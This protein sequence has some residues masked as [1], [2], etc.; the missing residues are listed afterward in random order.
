MEII[1]LALVSKKVDFSWIFLQ[2]ST[3]IP[4]S[5]TNK[6][7]FARPLIV[8]FLVFVFVFGG[9]NLGIRPH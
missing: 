9:T 8:Y 2:N 6:S 1:E 5:E 7:K 4:R 3:G